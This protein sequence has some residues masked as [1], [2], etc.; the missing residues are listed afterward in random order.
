MT[1]PTNGTH[2]PVNR[3]AC[4]VAR[5]AL[6]P[7]HGFIGVLLT[8]AGLGY[9]FGAPRPMSVEAEL[10]PVVRSAW[11][12]CL[13]A[14]GICLLTGVAIGRLRTEKAGQW[15]IAAGSVAF[16]IAAFTAAGWRAMYAG[17][18]TLAIGVACVVATSDRIWEWAQATLA[19]GGPDEQ[20]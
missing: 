13:L 3:G 11:G 14:G 16:A 5:L 6:R 12:V 4:A 2:R 8:V 18:L 15:L 1:T 7:L 10:P 17:G 19:R 9:L 20:R